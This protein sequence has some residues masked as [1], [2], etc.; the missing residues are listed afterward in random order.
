[1]AKQ[2]KPSRAGEPAADGY[3][4][5]SQRP[6]EI[7]FFLLPLIVFYE[8]G[9]LVYLR[10]SG[11]VLTN[12]AHEA[13]LRIFE[14]F[15]LDGASLS[16]PALS[17]PGALLVVVLLTWQVLARQKWEV[18]LR[19][20]GLMALE[21]VAL[22]LPLL[23]FAQLIAQAFGAVAPA[24]LGADAAE[25]TLRKL[26]LAGQ[27]AIAMGAGLYEELIFR[28]TLIAVLHTAFVDALKWPERRSTILAVVLSAIAFAFYHPLRDSHGAFDL[29]RFASLLVAGGYFGAIFAKR[30]FGI[31]VGAHAA[32]DIAALLLAARAG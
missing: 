5:R 11:V 21:S 8:V 2:S 25:T 23:V 27:V 13:L 12:K 15:G 14:A 17:L 19:T 29:P 28:M 16:L 20:V 18:D 3:F 24:A 9:L 4:L 7:L 1:M 30:G 32:Y 22:A 6:L 10:G 26:P 31:V